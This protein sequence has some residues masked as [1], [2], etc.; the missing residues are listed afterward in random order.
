MKRLLIALSL[1]AITVF[2]NP[3]FAS[4]IVKVVRPHARTKPH[5]VVT[6]PADEYFGHQRY[7][8]LGIRNALHDLNIRYDGTAARTPSLYAGAAGLENAMQ[9]WGKKYRG[10]LWLAHYLFHLDQ[11]YMRVPPALGHA[12]VASTSRWIISAYPNTYYS[13][14]LKHIASIRSTVVRSASPTP[15]S[16]ATPTPPSDATPTPPSNAAPTPRSDATAAPPTEQ[17]TT[18]PIAPG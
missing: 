18:G 17:P 8:I 1:A 15:S 14:Y 10:D 16:D 6:A 9:D 11:L 12:K 2:P 13:R 7:S 3:A 4:H 5:R